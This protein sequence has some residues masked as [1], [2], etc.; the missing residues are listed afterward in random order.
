[1]SELELEINTNIE[2]QESD[3]DEYDDEEI[4]RI[5]CDCDCL[6]ETLARKNEY[7]LH[8]DATK[9]SNPN[10]V[11]A[12]S[13][14]SCVVYNVNDR[15][16]AKITEL[17]EHT[18]KII[19]CRFSNNNNN[20]IYTASS[21]G[22]V[23]LWDIR[24]PKESTVNFIDNTVENEK[25]RK[26]FNCFDISHNDRMLAAGTDLSGGD[27]FL[28]FWDIRNQKL[29]GAYWE[30]HT[31][32]ITQVKFHPDDMNKLISGSTDGLINIYDLSQT[33]EDDALTE[34]LNSESSVEQL[35]WFKKKGKYSISCVTHTSDLQLWNTDDAEPYRRICRAELARSIKKRSDNYTYI[36]TSLQSKNSLIILVGSNFGNGECLRGL[37]V[38]DKDIQPYI[39]FKR[40]K[41]R[42]RCSWYNPDINILMS[43]GE[44]G[45][46][47]CWR[48]KE[49]NNL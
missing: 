8:L 38:K 41:Q 31:D 1:M 6:S 13:D 33:C 4:N 14:H 39:G 47:N 25:D 48:L 36:A 17:T 29:L 44:N 45:I 42:V 34:S 22:L 28:L 15:Q 23:K 35:L 49:N 20:L 10:V 46:F 30:S 11:A 9:E 24:A 3:S 18:N 16:V 43:G 40:N 12:L 2:K 32:D 37:Q 19:D 27:S 5:F 26:T 7:V 21:D